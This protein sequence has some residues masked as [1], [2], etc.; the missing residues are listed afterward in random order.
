MT[1]VE[2]RRIGVKDML[3]Q[4]G[5]RRGYMH[6]SD[7]MAFKAMI[8]G[9]IT[10][11]SPA[12]LKEAFEGISFN[13]CGLARITSEEM[14]KSDLVPLSSKQVLLDKMMYGDKEHL[15]FLYELAKTNEADEAFYKVIVDDFTKVMLIDGFGGSKGL[16]A[17]HEV[18]GQE[19]LH[20]VKHFRSSINNGF[21]Q[22]LLIDYASDLEGTPEGEIAQMM[23]LRHTPH[24]EYVY[25]F[26]MT[27]WFEPTKAATHAAITYLFERKSYGNLLEF[28]SWSWQEEV[29]KQEIEALFLNTPGED[30]DNELLE[31]KGSEKVQNLAISLLE[32][33][34]VMYN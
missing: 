18:L 4:G 11:D 27:S 7:L 2:A 8:D 13:H 1:L 10:E 9:P 12:E 33:R 31:V 34:D 3:F 25:D 16:K 29:Q 5:D 30:V 15:L 22:N 21:L 17:V 23:F 14:L 19:I 24:T 26:L 6:P 32:K 28:M 20:F